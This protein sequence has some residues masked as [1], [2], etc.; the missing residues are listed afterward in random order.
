MTIPGEVVQILHNIYQEN[1]I[2]IPDP[3]VEYDNLYIAI[4]VGICL[5]ILLTCMIIIYFRYCRGKFAPKYITREGKMRIINIKTKE[6]PK[7]DDL[8]LSYLQDS[9]V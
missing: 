7:G 5:I 1:C 6:N 2:I 3:P 4:I 8:M 9:S